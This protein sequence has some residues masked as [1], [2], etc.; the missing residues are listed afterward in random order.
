MELSEKEAA[1][2]SPAVMTRELE[3]PP[4]WAARSGIPPSTFD[5]SDLVLLGGS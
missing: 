4:A 1:Q 3:N 5:L 2:S